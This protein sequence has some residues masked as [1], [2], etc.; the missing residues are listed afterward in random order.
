MKE[1]EEEGVETIVVA[2]AV[3]EEEEED[4]GHQEVRIPPPVNVA[5]FINAKLWVGSRL[6]ITY[7]SVYP[8]LLT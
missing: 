5:S 3:E 4:L 1:E 7:T 8:F 2:L 6:I